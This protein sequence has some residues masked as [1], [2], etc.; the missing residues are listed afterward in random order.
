MKYIQT[1][2]LRPTAEQAAKIR[3]RFALAVYAYNWGLQ[4]TER[5]WESE[6][7]HLSLFDIV[8]LYRHHVNFELRRPYGRE[9]HEALVHLDYA[10]YSYFQ[11]WTD[12]PRP[13][14]SKNAV[15]CTVRA[16]AI[17]LDYKR[18]TARLPFAGRVRCNLYRTLPGKPTTVTIKEVKT[19]VFVLAFLTESD[20]I[21]CTDPSP[22][23]IGIDLGLKHFAT[24]SNG[25]TI[26]FPEKFWDDHDVRHE[27][28][29]QRRVKRCREGSKNYEKARLQLKHFHERKANQRKDFHY[30][31]AARLT[32][33]FKAIAV[34]DLNI[35]EM[36]QKKVG[37]R[38]N[39]NRNLQH[40]GLKQFLYR[41]EA[42]C[43]RTGT[44]FLQIDRFAPT[45]KTCHVCGYKRQKL[46]LDIR[47]WTCPQCGTHHDRD[48][49][50][51]INIK[52]LGQQL[53]QTLPD[54][55]GEVLTAERSNRPRCETVKADKAPKPSPARPSQ[56]EKEHTRTRLADK[57][58]KQQSLTASDFLKVLQPVVKPQKISELSDTSIRQLG[59]VRHSLSVE[60]RRQMMAEKCETLR[61]SLLDVLSQV[62]PTI[63]HM[64]PDEYTRQFNAVLDGWL[65]VQ[66]I[67]RDE[68]T[69]T[70]PVTPG[71]CIFWH[72]YINRIIK[73]L[74]KI[75]I[76]V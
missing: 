2:R 56:E 47:E 36:K 49:N 51:A 44:Q 28:H 59:S 73:N 58:G 67:C 18:Q 9:E 38:R 8:D 72:L 50:A 37:Y 40:Y 25:E 4:E 66:Q 62:P 43:L 60:W 12:K 42:R 41:L 75:K 1:Y 11:R 52:L 29:L 24:L 61:L 33:R 34:E 6:H 68:K 13:K 65:Y 74:K 30:Q 45:S 19:G 63:E 14:E 17:L 23:V 16:D 15:T 31:Q 10:Y 76:V 27:Q 46:T 64:H 35:E 26:D 57:Q 70:Y 7:R 69:L 22:E 39:L 21:R 71:N 32:K 20:D 53:Q 55:D 3:Q 48:V 54:G 5:V